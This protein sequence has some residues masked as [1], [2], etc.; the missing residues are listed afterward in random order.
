[1]EYD[2]ESPTVFCTKLVGI[3]EKLK[4][5]KLELFGGHSQFSLALKEGFTKAF[6]DLDEVRGLRVSLSRKT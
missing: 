5:T 6:Q 2:T 3:Y 1:M 4:Q